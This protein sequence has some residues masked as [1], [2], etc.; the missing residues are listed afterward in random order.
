MYT[1]ECLNAFGLPL[2]SLSPGDDTVGQ[3]HEH[4]IHWI[5]QLFTPQHQD[6]AATVN[7]YVVQPE[8]TLLV[9]SSFMTIQGEGPYAG[10]P[11]YFIRLGGCNYGPKTHF[12][13]FCDTDFRLT[14]SK[15]VSFE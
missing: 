5:Q 9:R 10:R 3:Q 2:I 4:D 15:N 1:L 7:T 8:D 13:Q 11:A 12:C 6:P 14:E